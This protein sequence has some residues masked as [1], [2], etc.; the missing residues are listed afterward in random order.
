MNMDDDH[1]EEEDIMS[2]HLE[3]PAL[4]WLTGGDGRR[5]GCTRAEEIEV[6]TL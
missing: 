4:I 6:S 3:Y 1:L 2:D 5:D